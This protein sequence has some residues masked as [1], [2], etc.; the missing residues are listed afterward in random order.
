MGGESPNVDLIRLGF[1][2]YE[3]EG[4]EGLLAL[5]DP[6][7][8]IFIEP[9]LAETGTYR[10]HEGLRYAGREW[11]EAWQDFRLEPT[12]FIEVGESI[13][14]VPNHQVAIGRESGV[15]VE[16]DVAYLIEFREG[17]CTR[18]HTYAETDRALEVA[19]RL[20]NEQ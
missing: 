11:L 6:E 17:K 12:G 1:T 10:G 14:V 2:A 19:E 4:V 15:R 8:E 9:T 5:A 3:R 16:G 13:V 20:A 18:F 7:I